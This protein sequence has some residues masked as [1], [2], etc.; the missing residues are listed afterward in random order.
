MYDLLS[1]E[2]IRVNFLLEY[3]YIILSFKF[4]FFLFLI[5][6]LSTQFLLLLRTAC[7]TLLV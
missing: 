7:E 5:S 1:L 3:N 6:I 2:V 4:Y